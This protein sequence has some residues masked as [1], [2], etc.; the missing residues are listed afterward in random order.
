MNATPNPTGGLCPVRATTVADGRI[1]YDI[2]LKHMPDLAQ[3][4]HDS[5]P[6]V[7]TVDDLVYERK[8]MCVYDENGY[9]YVDRHSDANKCAAKVLTEPSGATH[10]PLFISPTGTVQC[11]SSCFY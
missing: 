1:L 2:E 6:G 8:A 11:S 9:I 3:C 5:I 10:R 7:D 4:P